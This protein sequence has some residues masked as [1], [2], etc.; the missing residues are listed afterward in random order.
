[1]RHLA[2]LIC[3]AVAA[4][5][6]VAALQQRRRVRAALEAASLA[7]IAP[8]G[9][10]S[11]AAFGEI[12]RPIILFALAYAGLKTTFVYFAFGG[13]VLFSLFDLGGFLALLAGY[14]TWISMRTRYRFSA[15]PQPALAESK[16]EVSDG[17]VVRLDRAVAGVRRDPGHRPVR[18]ALGEAIDP[19]RPGARAG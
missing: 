10:T 5:F 2:G 9:E 6:L 12:A 15:V 7:G 1:M 16:P 14:G 3:L 4:A 18:T 13:A 11:L 8:A 17:R 19:Q